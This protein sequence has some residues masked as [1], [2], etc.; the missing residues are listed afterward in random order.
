MIAKL[1]CWHSPQLKQGDS[2]F[3]HYCIGWYHSVSQCLTQCPQARLYC[4]RM[5]YGAVLYVLY[6]LHLQS[7]IQDI[8]TGIGV[9]IVSCMALWTLP[10]ADGKILY[11][12]IFIPTTGTRLTAW[13]HCRY[14]YNVIPIPDRFICEHIKELRPRCR[15]NVLCQFMITHHV[16][17]FQILYADGLVFT[18]QLR[19]FIL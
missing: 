9:P 10:L 15:A 12:W 11:Q 8:Y 4:S 3:N 2:C 7:F 19:G 16:F 17:Y 14:F 1:V 5:P 13:V 6:W 18:N